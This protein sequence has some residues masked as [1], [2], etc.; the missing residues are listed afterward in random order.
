[1]SLLTAANLTKRYSGV[2]ALSQ[3]QFELR[4][5]EVH[6]LVGENGAGKST[7]C[8]IL[9]GITQADEG[10]MTLAGQP[11]APRTRRE[12]EHAGVR[13]VMQ[14]LNLLPTLT[15]A[16]NIFIDSMPRRLGV[17]R[18]RKMN[19]AAQRAIDGVGLTNVRPNQLVASLGVGQ[20]QLVEI[21][22]AL[23]RKCQVLV[24]DEPT[25]ALTAPEI[26]LLFAQIRRLK[27]AGV[28]IIYVSHRMEEIRA[29]A[30]R[31][32][33]L[34][35]GQW[36]ATRNTSEIT[37]EETV[38]LMVG[39]DLSQTVVREKSSQDAPGAV[40]LSVRHLSSGIVRDVS[41]DARRGEILGFA[42]LMGSGRT[43]T[44]RAV[45]GADS[46]DSGEIVL[47][48]AR[49]RIRSPRDA[50]R[51][52]IALLTEDRKSQGL[53][54]PLQ[55]DLNTSLPRMSAVTRLRGWIDRRRERDV[56]QRYI[57]ALSIR[58]RS[59]RQRAVELSGGNQQ[60]V[61]LAKWLLRDCDV[62]IFDEPTRGIDVGA[63]FE[64]YHLLADL[65][66]K[67]KAVIVVSSDLLELTAIADRIAVMSAGRLVQTFERGQ[68]TQEL[69][70]Q[71]ALSGYQNRSAKSA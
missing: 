69:I 3:A 40:A 47:N 6:A 44:M 62:L 58:C 71:A 18:Y 45:F 30:D 11:H 52:G 7:L 14:E 59:P 25:A 67:G 43:E 49:L 26:E 37:H 35:D 24:L 56:A 33:V 64:I 31:I 15:V 23:S 16:E 22:A 39:R 53:L 54:L 36:I 68:W 63:K 57:K 10:T 28:G 38:R 65:A 1:M 27:A 46:I 51:N 55:I 5:G 41:F 12:A 48:G 20:Q 9:C 29:M 19:D 60:K 2:A 32:T 50:V 17:V 13:M 21:A 4:R 70:M 66:H 34:R 42:G 8:R 61:V